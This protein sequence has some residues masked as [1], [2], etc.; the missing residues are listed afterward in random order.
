MSDQTIATLLAIS[1][2]T[3]LWIGFTTAEAVKAVAAARRR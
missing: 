1:P 2:F 3:L